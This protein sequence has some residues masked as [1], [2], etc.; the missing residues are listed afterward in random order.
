[1]AAPELEAGFNTSGPRGKLDQYILVLG[2]VL[3]RPELQTPTQRGRQLR[4][5]VG[6]EGVLWAVREAWPQAEHFWKVTASFQGFLQ[7][8]LWR[9]FP[10]M[11]EYRFLHPAYRP[12]PTQLSTPHSPIIDWLPWPD[13]RDQVIHHQDQLDVDLV[14]KLAIQNVVAHRRTRASR[15]SIRFENRDHETSTTT[16][17]TKKTSF[18]VWEL[19]LLEEQ[20]GSRPPASAHHLVYR[21]QSVPVQALEKAYGLEF[22]DFQT[23]RLHRQFFDS[24]PALFVDSALSDYAVQTMP[25]VQQQR[26]P[27]RDQLGS[28]RDLS[29]QAVERL[30]RAIERLLVQA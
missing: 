13:L 18:R 24:F 7:S 26:R 21:P 16:A 9:N 10:A 25:A 3:Q 14:C 22:D 28:P 4:Q 2:Q 15:Q 8:E 19:C 27:D 20:A 23:Q 12:T 1:M 17:T 30:E 29:P 5:K 11:A 6:I